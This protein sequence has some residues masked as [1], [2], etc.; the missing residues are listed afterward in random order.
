MY[1]VVHACTSTRVL[2]IILHFLRNRYKH[3]TDS[4]NLTWIIRHFVNRHVLYTSLLLLHNC[5]WIYLWSFFLSITTLTYFMSTFSVSRFICKNNM[6]IKS[7]SLWKLY[8]N[9]QSRWTIL[10]LKSNNRENKSI[11][12][13]HFSQLKTQQIQKL[14]ELYKMD[15]ELFEYDI[16]AFLHQ[17]K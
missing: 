15:F 8:N 7:K 2:P 1:F 9:L 6:L 4:T 5:Y 10:F 16:D 3:V 12:M 13:Q 14:Y 11:T 17:E